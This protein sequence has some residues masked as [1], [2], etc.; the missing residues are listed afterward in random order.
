[1]MRGRLGLEKIRIP[2]NARH[3]R[4]QQVFMLVRN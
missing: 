2:Y 3:S 1:M 4:L